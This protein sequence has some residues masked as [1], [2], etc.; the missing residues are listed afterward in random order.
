MEEMNNKFKKGVLKIIILNCLKERDKYGGEII[1]ELYE[2]S[3]G[4]F[5][6]KAGTLYS[7]VHRFDEKNL[8]EHYWGKSDET[9]RRKY[10]HLTKEGRESLSLEINKLDRVVKN[11]NSLLN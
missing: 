2:K 1:K 11:I 3:N 6:L 9:A 10:Y 4:F 8:V 5:D 7:I